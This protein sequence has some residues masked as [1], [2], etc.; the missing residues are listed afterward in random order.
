[1]AQFAAKFRG[2]LQLFAAKTVFRDFDL[3]SSQGF[4]GRVGQ[5]GAIFR[6]LDFNRRW[7]MNA[8]GKNNA[9]LDRLK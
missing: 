1:L 9:W 2:F 7:Q 5:Y 6:N 4:G 8:D 3:P